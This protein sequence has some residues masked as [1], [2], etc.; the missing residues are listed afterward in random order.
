MKWFHH[1]FLSRQGL[2][3]IQRSGI[4]SDGCTTTTEGHVNYD[5]LAWWKDTNKT[6]DVDMLVLS[7]GKFDFATT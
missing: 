7:M 1:S 2:T 6:G 4:D 3:P 5:G